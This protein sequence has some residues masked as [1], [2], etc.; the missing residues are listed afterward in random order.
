MTGPT[1]G[2]IGMEERAVLDR[3]LLGLSER[4]SVQRNGARQFCGALV[5]IDRT[6]GKATDIKRIYLK[7]IA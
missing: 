3:F 5:A 6:S 2:I 4:F 7:G 1:E